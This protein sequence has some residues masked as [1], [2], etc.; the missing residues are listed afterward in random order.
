MTMKIH[1]TAQQLV[2]A[3]YEKS[4]RATALETYTDYLEDK[5]ISELEIKDWQTATAL[6]KRVQA[7]E[8]VQMTCDDYRIM[9]AALSRFLAIT[10]VESLKKDEKLENVVAAVGAH[11]SNRLVNGVLVG[12]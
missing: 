6:L 12:A 1:S 11:N 4:L 2:A 8:E 10:Y 5:M 3:D 9:T 7:N